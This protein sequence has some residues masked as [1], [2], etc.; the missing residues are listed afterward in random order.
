M[1]RPRDRALMSFKLQ[2]AQFFV[3]SAIGS[4]EKLNN[5]KVSENKPKL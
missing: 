3:I 5:H 1:I 2:I 4:S